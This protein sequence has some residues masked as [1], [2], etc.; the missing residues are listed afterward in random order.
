MCRSPLYNRSVLQLLL[1]PA[2][3]FG[4]K[5][6]LFAVSLSN[7]IFLPKVRFPLVCSVINV[8]NL[9]QINLDSGVGICFTLVFFLSFRAD[10]GPKST[11]PSLANICQWLPLTVSHPQ[12]FC[13]DSLWPCCVL[14]VPIAE[15]HFLV[16]FPVFGKMDLQLKQISI[17]FLR[18][19]RQ[20][21]Y[22]TGLQCDSSLSLI[23]YYPK[24]NQL[25]F[26]TML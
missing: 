9:W 23:P 15:H 5:A 20:G 16:L 11:K 24:E 18:E 25:I 12:I 6:T 19:S 7:H 21:N 22:T 13:F 3:S 2:S 10:V 17:H 1:L 8:C 14:P 26:F 4:G